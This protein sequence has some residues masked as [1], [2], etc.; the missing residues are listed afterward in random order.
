MMSGLKGQ[1]GGQRRL[2]ASQ[3]YSEWDLLQKEFIGQ[4]GKVC[5]T[6]I[7]DR[8]GKKIKNWKRICRACK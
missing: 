7:W 5:S 4:V 3:C 2:K 8:R 1:E 6:G